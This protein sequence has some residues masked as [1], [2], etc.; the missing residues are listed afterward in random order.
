M[1]LLSPVV[2]SWLRITEATQVTAH[3]WPPLGSKTHLKV[4]RDGSFTTILREEPELLWPED[5]DVDVAESLA[6]SYK[7]DQECGVAQTS[8]ILA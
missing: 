4:E 8:A 1:V 6:V 7:R 2:R 5:R 3:S